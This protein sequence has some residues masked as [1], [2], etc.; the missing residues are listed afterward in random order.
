METSHKVVRGAEVNRAANTMPV[1]PVAMYAS[2][3]A[4]GLQYG[5]K[6][7][8]LS[9]VRTIAPAAEAPPAEAPQPQPAA[10]SAGGH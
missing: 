10:V 8:L 1:D 9:N 5:P 6:F 2:L 3:N 7:R 4:T